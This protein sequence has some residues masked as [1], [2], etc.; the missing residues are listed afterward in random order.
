[1]V[2]VVNRII[3]QGVRSRASDIHIEPQEKAVRVRYRVDGAMVEAIQLPPSMAPALASRVKV[4]ANLNIVERRRP[5][6][7]S[8]A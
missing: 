7:G 5:Q 8:S 3:T 2:Q 4:M 1:M 6:D